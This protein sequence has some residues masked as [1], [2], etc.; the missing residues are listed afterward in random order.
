M[1]KKC[2]ECGDSM[3]GFFGTPE[4]R[5]N[6]NVCVQCVNKRS[7]E[8]KRRSRESVAQSDHKA[9]SSDEFKSSANAITFLDV[10]NNV[11]FFIGCLSVLYTLFLAAYL[12]EVLVALSGIA[13]ALAALVGWCITR[14]L[15]GVAKDL[16][17]SRDNTDKLLTLINEKLDSEKQP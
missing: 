7:A 9:T 14:V 17:V 2:S 16:R 12:S 3:G 1:A 4:S 5:A 11:V 10:V 13:A 8:Q 15:I 6:P